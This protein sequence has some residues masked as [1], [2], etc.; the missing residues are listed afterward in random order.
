[1]FP[2][3]VKTLTRSRSLCQALSFTKG[4][5]HTWYP[6]ITTRNM[7]RTA[8][9]ASFQVKMGLFSM[10]YAWSKPWKWYAVQSH[11]DT[12]EGSKGFS[13]ILP[14]GAR[15][16]GH[17]WCVHQD[18]Q[19]RWTVW[20][21]FRQKLNLV[22]SHFTS[23]RLTIQEARRTWRRRRRIGPTARVCMAYTW[24]GFFVIWDL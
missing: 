14:R 5:A 3:Y 17:L 22:T 12:C 2:C 11:Y 19:A 13:E 8:E 23:W 4:H 6:I 7:V 15:H 1:M 10:I 9:T 24:S 18:S 21:Y 20:S 16:G